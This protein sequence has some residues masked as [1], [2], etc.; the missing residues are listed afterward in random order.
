VAA[1]RRGNAASLRP[2]FLAATPHAHPQI[3]AGAFQATGWPSVVAIMANWYGKGKRGLVMG[4]WNAHTSL[5][6]IAGTMVAAACL[7]YG[8]GYSFVVPGVA[9]SLLGVAVYLLLT[10]QPSDVGLAAAGSY[11]A[12]KS[13]DE[14][15]AVRVR[16]HV[17]GGGR[18]LGRWAWWEWGGMCGCV[19]LLEQWR[20]RA[21]RVVP[22]L[23]CQQS[24]PASIP[25]RPRLPAPH[26]PK[27][28]PCSPRR[29]TTTPPRS[30]PP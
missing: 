17:G 6:N 8:W 19:P 27:N 5:G 9:I 14:V 12:V 4:I 26:L 29:T 1:A 21:R 30:R 11:E 23:E 22:P 28:P 25:Q 3:F 16:N 18:G 20:P 15:R 10:V 13:T 7:Q 2:T 24:R